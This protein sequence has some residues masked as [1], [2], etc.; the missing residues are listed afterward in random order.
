VA[1]VVADRLFLPSLA[2]GG[3]REA[4][5]GVMSIITD[6]LR[7]LRLRACRRSGTSPLRGE[8]A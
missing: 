4:G 2:R 8:G 1:A 5:G 7:P 6:S 3:A